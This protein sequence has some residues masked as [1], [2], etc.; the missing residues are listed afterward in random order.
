[1]QN[2]MTRVATCTFIRTYSDQD[3]KITCVAR[4]NQRDML[5]QFVRCEPLTEVAEDCTRLECEAVQFR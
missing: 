5:T 1:M 2:G 4:M 3:I